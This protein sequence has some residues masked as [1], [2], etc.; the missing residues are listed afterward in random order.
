MKPPTKAEAEP[1]A[2]ARVTR[3][4]FMVTKEKGVGLCG[5]VWD[6]SGG[7]DGVR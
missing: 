5:V 4:V 2:S 1:A 6:G 7:G 3:V